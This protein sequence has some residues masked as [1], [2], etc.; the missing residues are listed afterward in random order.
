M[1][2]QYFGYYLLSK[3]IITKE[4]LK[5]VLS[6]ENKTRVKLGVLAID[7]GYM[8][9]SEVTEIHKMQMAQDRR[10]GDLAVEKGFLSEDQ[11]MLL[12]SKQ[13]ESHTTLGQVLVDENIMNYEDYEQLLIQYKKDSGFSDEEIKI[14]KS[15]DSD[16]ILELFIDMENTDEVKLFKDYVELFI[17][18]IIRFV[19]RNVVI[20][21]PYLAEAYTYENHAVQ[22]I[23][24][25]YALSTGLSASDEVI[26]N[27]ATIY[28][29]MLISEVNELAKDAIGEFMNCQNG[30]F[31][32]N[33]YHK[34]INCNLEPQ[35]YKEKGIITSQNKL[36]VLPCELTFGKFDIL[37]N[38]KGV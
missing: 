31:I 14:L 15:N 25:F 21:K 32:S 20:G 2:N 24:G 13:K 23:V 9:S 18:N 19:D 35:D 1:F 16:A 5:F 6:D 27:F 12:L 4:K 28:A 11:L 22:D 33:L 7:A 10:F 37:F 30:L 26:A 38:I 3:N 36:F 8:T 29:H 34:G 17:R